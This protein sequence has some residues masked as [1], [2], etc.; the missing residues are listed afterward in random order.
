MTTPRSAK[1]GIHAGE[2]SMTSSPPDLAMCSATDLEKI[3]GNGASTT[4][5]LPPVS[6]FQSGP[7]KFFGSSACRPASAILAMP[8]PLKFLFAAF[9]AVVA[10][11][12]PPSE[13]RSAA[14]AFL[15]AMKN[16]PAAAA[17]AVILAVS[18]RKL[19][20]SI[21][22][23]RRAGSSPASS[24]SSGPICSSSLTFGPSLRVAR[25]M[26]GGSSLC[27]PG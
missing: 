9:A 22:A 21:G 24:K 26:T 12:S 18:R 3:S 27:L 5:T 16:G 8:T 11:G 20:R 15:A 6:L 25:C 19:L 17:A 13:A 10:I 1:S 14:L 2:V 23:S 7:E 4:L